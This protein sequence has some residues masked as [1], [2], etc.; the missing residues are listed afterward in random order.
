MVQ[1]QI[2]GGDLDEWFGLVGRDGVVD[3]AVYRAEGVDRGRDDPLRAVGSAQV[4]DQHFGATRRIE[5]GG[6]GGQGLVE[7]VDQQ[8]RGPTFE[9]RGRDALADPAGGA[10]DNRDMPP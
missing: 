8:H 1:G 6:G 5:F 2:L 7:D 9:E 3:Q 4:G 10:G